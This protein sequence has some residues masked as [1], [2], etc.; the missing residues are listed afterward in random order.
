MSERTDHAD[1]IGTLHPK[2]YGYEAVCSVPRC[3]WTLGKQSRVAAED[4][5]RGHASLSHPPVIKV[6]R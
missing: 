6:Y 5:L 1:E 4:G 2:P 3:G